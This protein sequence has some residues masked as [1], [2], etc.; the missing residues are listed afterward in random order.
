MTTPPPT[1]SAPPAEPVVLGR[2]TLR[3]VTWIWI[4]SFVLTV[5]TFGHGG[6]AFRYGIAVAL[7]SA[8]LL[9]LLPGLFFVV[10]VFRHS[11][12]TAVP[13]LRQC[14]M[15]SGAAMTVLGVLLILAGVRLAVC[16]VVGVLGILIGVRAWTLPRPAAPARAVLEHMAFPV[17]G[18]V[19]LP[20]LFRMLSFS[21]GTKENAYIAE[22]Q[23]DLRTLV[24]AE[25]AFRA[26]S[27]RFGNQR[28]LYDVA[29]SG[30]SITI[31]LAPDRT[32]WWA[33]AL[34]WRTTTRCG[35]WVVARPPDGM[36]GAKEAEPKCWEVR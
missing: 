5:A 9:V 29:S 36:H 13:D 2:I 28:E 20:L 19:S 14:G 35:I 22:M 30:D 10:Y 23:Y 27:G 6:N 11:T 15:I 32:G 3:V 24:T 34:N 1:S 33:A 26:D 16:V 21:E 17:A 4:V 18:L 25:E 8:F 31:T 12:S 7:L